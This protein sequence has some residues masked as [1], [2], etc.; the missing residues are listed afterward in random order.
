M[1]VR[2]ATLDDIPQMQV[3]RNTVTENALS[4][5]GLVTE[6]D[7][8]EYLG[9]R[10]KG[11]VFE[12]ELEIQGFAIVDMQECNVWAL[13]VKPGRE[14]AGIGRKLH[15]TMLDW[16]FTQTKTMIWLGTAAATRAEAFYRKAGWLENGMHGKEIRF[17]MS[18]QSWAE[19]QN[20][21]QQ[22]I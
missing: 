1:P 19:I 22:A 4:D 3:I 20:K 21:K 15:D 9:N 18:A 5:P 11:W 7:Y 12:H 13:F 17:E 14:G 16:Y 10:G 8:R 6:A 2:P